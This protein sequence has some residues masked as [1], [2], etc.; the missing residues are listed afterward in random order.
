MRFKNVLNPRLAQMFCEFCHS[1]DV[2][3]IFHLVSKLE[4]EEI[5]F[6]I[7]FHA[8]GFHIGYPSLNKEGGKATVCSVILS[9]M[10]YGAEKGL[11]EISGLLTPEEEE[12]DTVVGNLT[13]S[14]VYLRI[15]D[16]YRRH[17]FET[18]DT[19]HYK[20][21]DPEDYPCLE[22]CYGDAYEEDYRP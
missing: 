7:E 20:N 14:A 22:C 6:E 18:C 9:P 13:G 17:M 12:R 8:R 15:R 3:E 1:Y 4:F 16:H 2:E 5:P 21:L 10:S 11:L 19:C